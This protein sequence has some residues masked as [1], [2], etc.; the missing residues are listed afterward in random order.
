MWPILGSGGTSKPDFPCRL[1]GTQFAVRLVPIPAA[2]WLKRFVP[3]WNLGWDTAKLALNYAMQFARDME[4][5]LAD[6][7]VG[8]YVNK[9]TLGY[10][11]PGQ[12]AVREFLDRGAKAGLIP[13]AGEIDFV[14]GGVEQT[15]E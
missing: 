8:M 3:A 7:F 9:W 15:K 2:G 11:E 10:G 13:S 14:A 5:E 4:T 6:Q 12:R 1:A